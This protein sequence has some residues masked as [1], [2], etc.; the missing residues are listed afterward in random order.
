MTCFAGI[1]WPLEAMPYWIRWF[2]Y[3]QPQTLPTEMLRHVLSRGWNIEDEG[4]WMGFAVTFGWLAFFLIS[5]AI[6]FRIKK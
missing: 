5:A 2:S 4:V 3:M 1:I 6:V